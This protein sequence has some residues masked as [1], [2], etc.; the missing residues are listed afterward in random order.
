VTI[1]WPE[2]FKLNKERALRGSNHEINT[3]SIRGGF[4]RLFGKGANEIFDS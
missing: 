4:G 3:E 1:P 2:E